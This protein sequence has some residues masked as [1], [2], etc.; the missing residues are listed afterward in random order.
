MTDQTTA[1]PSKIDPAQPIESCNDSSLPAVHTS[2][3]NRISLTLG[4][5]CYDLSAVQADALASSLYEAALRSG[6]DTVTPWAE[7]QVESVTLTSAPQSNKFGVS[8]VRSADF[9]DVKFLAMGWLY[10]GE[11]EDPDYPKNVVFI[12]VTQQ[13]EFELELGESHHQLSLT[14]VE[15]LYLGLARA[16]FVLKHRT[17]EVNGR[18]IRW[19]SVPKA[20]LGEACRTG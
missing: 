14:Q 12:K 10:E 13:D 6:A 20:A 1:S 3:G 5:E 18:S 4:G 2:D 9:T 17:W 8:E 11:G 7:H 16:A 15:L 19:H